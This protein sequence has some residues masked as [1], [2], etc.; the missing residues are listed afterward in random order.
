VRGYSVEIP[1]LGRIT[2]LPGSIWLPFGLHATFNG[3]L[4]ILAE[5]AARAGVPGT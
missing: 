2:A 3:I 4:L 5:A 1:G